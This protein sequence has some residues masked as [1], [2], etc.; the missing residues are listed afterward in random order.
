MTSKAYEHH[1]STMVD[2]T[3]YI[4]PKRPQHPLDDLLLTDEQR[5][6]R[7]TQLLMPATCMDD[8]KVINCVRRMNNWPQYETVDEFNAKHWPNADPFLRTIHE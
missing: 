1:S 5:L 2:P 4:D 3:V 6:Q 8:L 7:V